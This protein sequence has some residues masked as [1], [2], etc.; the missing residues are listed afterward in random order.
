VHQFVSWWLNDDRQLFDHVVS[1]WSHRSEPNVLF[2]HYSDLKADLESEMRRVAA[3]LGVAIDEERW[4]DLVERCTFDGM[5]RRSG[6]IADFDALFVGGAETFLY[7]GT[8]ERWRDVLTED[9]LTT[10]DR[11]SQ[12]LLPADAVGWAISGA[13]A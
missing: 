12:E 5:K 1:V 11:R 7:K 8:N 13:R 10:F 4:P 6:E 3:F 2:V 9:E